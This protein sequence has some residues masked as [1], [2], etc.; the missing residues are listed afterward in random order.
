[1]PQR[2]LEFEDYRDLRHASWRKVESQDCFRLE[3][4]WW[5]FGAEIEVKDSLTGVGLWARG[6]M[7]H[8]HIYNIYIYT[9][10]I[11]FLCR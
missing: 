3:S 2:C 9:Y 1:M 11:H 6:R 4:M 10:H 7:C 8:I 5:R